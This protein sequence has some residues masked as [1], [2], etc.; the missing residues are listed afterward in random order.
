MG[1]RGL[2]GFR[3]NNVDKIA[4]VHSDSY[5]TWLGVQT[6]KF[7]RTADADQLAKVAKRLKPVHEDRKPTQKQYDTLA[8][9]LEGVDQ[10]RANPEGTWYDALRALQGKWKPLYDGLP[11]ILNSAAFI[12]SCEWAYIYDVETTTL[13]IYCNSRVPRGLGRYNVRD[14][15]D[16][17]YVGP[18]RLT[19]LTLPA[20]QALSEDAIEQL[21]AMLEMHDRAT[22]HDSVSH[23]V[24]ERES[25]AKASYPGAPT[26]SPRFQLDNGWAASLRTLNPTRQ[27]GQD[28]ILILDVEPVPDRWVSISMPDALCLQDPSYGPMLQGLLDKG[29][30]DLTCKIY[31]QHATLARYRQVMAA[32]EAI[33]ALQGAGKTDLAPSLALALSEGEFRCPI[34]PGC[35]RQIRDKLKD[36]G[37]SGDAVEWLVLQPAPVQADLFADPPFFSHSGWLVCG[38]AINLVEAALVGERILP[39]AGF[40]NPMLKAVRSVCG[41]GSWSQADGLID[42]STDQQRA[43][44]A[45]IAQLLAEQSRDPSAPVPD[46]EIIDRMARFLR[47]R[48]SSAPLSWTQLVNDTNAFHADQ[49]D[50][51]QR[52]AELKQRDFAN[53]FFITG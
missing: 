19:A 41:W 6:L 25:P 9:H 47:A 13:E 49:T 8:K 26:A 51:A 1:T 16:A 30:V 29:V 48:T 5:P 43:N 53:E 11:F 35:D 44:A 2:I 31:H 37:F 14:T 24:L 10:L 20:I 45:M 32:R 3:V 18:R 21:C 4:Y 15:E 40:L 7:F 46:Q 36:Y 27:E 33:E 42:N 38:K 12:W 50:K 39:R 23:G 17:Q 28:Q 34:L 52:A 22:F